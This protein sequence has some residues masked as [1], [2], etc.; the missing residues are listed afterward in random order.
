MD[1]FV[2]PQ[3]SD[4]L[5]NRLFQFA[6]SY[7]YGKKNKKEVIFLLSKAKDTNHGAFQNLFLLFPDI[8]IKENAFI[9]NEI[10]EHK[11]YYEY[12]E[13]ENRKGSVLIRGYRQSYRYFE[14]VEIKPNF[15]NAISRERIEHLNDRYLKN[16]KDMFFI[17]IR[18]GDYLRLPHHQINITKY[19]SEA[20]KH[21]P[22]NAKLLF[23]SDDI[24]F[25]KQ[26]FP[27]REFCEETDELEN[28]YVMSNCLRGSIVGNSTFSYWGSYFA[29][30]NNKEYKAIFPKPLGQDMPYPQDFYPPYSIIISAL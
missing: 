18:L 17:H 4:G 28:L 10:E 9:M 1:N 12:K 29:Y 11:N 21:I 16:K 15:E 27:N 30:L 2:T 19:Y 3:L 20:F 25:A 22:E 26:I 6:C 5:G 14:N 13:I 7:A 23:F 8:Q 24:S